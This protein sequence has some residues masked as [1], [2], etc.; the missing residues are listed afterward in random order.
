VKSTSNYGQRSQ[1]SS[2]Y[3][4]K[5][6]YRRVVNRKRQR[7]AE[8]SWHWQWKVPNTSSLHFATL[9]MFT[10]TAGY[11]DGVI[12]HRYCPVWHAG[13]P[14]HRTRNLGSY[15]GSSFRRATKRAQA[16]VANLS[17][18][19]TRQSHVSYARISRRDTTVV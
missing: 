17:T 1:S 11:Y 5:E 14:T 8:T 12:F 2:H 16:V 18:E 9:T 3:D 13:F 15:Q 10:H 7:R 6:G 19:V 4:C